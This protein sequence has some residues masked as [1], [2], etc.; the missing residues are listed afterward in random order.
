MCTIL[1]PLRHV[2]LHFQNMSEA[3]S[4]GYE[5]QRITSELTEHVCVALTLILR[6]RHVAQILAWVLEIKRVFTL[7][8]E[9][10]L[11]R[12]PTVNAVF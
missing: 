2:R 8:L 1:C 9:E 12:A 3:G 5:K 4:Y 7:V 10:Y 6:S 11:L